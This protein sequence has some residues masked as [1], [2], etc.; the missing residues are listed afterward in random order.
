MKKIL[1]ALVTVTALTGA[2]IGSYHLMVWF[3]DAQTLIRISHHWINFLP[4]YTDYRWGILFVAGWSITIYA[5]FCKLVRE[6]KKH[7]AEQLLG[8]LIISII[9]GMMVGSIIAITNVKVSEIYPLIGMI[10]VIIGFMMIGSR[11]GFEGAFF[12]ALTICLGYGLAGIFFAALAT[13]II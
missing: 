2:L 13:N 6:H 11:E 10:L 12:A 4:T 1:I 8:Y 5:I 9:S 3:L 7:T